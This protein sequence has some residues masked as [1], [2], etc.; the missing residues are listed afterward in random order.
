[1]PLQ[2]YIFLSESESEKKGSHIVIL[3]II[4]STY[5]V[6]SH[7]DIEMLIRNITAQ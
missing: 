6:A 4:F 2:L 1:M 7:M 5:G 3:I